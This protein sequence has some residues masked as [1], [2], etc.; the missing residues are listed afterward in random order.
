MTMGARAFAPLA[1]RAAAAAITCSANL[2]YVLVMTDREIRSQPDIEVG[3]LKIWVHNRQFPEV[4]DYWDGNWLNVTVRCR[5]VEAHGAILTSPE[6][7]GFA[8]SC[9]ACL[10]GSAQVV[11]LRCT[12]PNL[13]LSFRKSDNLGHFTGEVRITPDHMAERH[14]YMF[15]IDQSFLPTIIRQCQDVLATYPIRGKP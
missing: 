8:Q 2:R 13:D 1:L 4:Y 14:T 3:H 12:E 9:S 10:Q 5:T 11:E 6:I 15:D 7:H